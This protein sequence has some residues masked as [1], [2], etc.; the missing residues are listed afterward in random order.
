MICQKWY[1]FSQYTALQAFSKKDSYY[2]FH[3][4]IRVTF[5]YEV[6]ANTPSSLSTRMQGV[7]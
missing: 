3:L 7:E 2:A 4:I 6:V 1:V 5:T